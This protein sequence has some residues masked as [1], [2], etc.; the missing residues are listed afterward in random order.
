MAKNQTK[1]RQ[2]K[3]WRIEVIDSNRFVVQEQFSKHWR[4]TPNQ[5]KCILSIKPLKQPVFRA[6]KVKADSESTFKYLNQRT[7]AKIHRPSK[8]TDKWTTVANVRLH[9]HPERSSVTDD[10][11][12]KVPQKFFRFVSYNPS[13]LCK[14]YFRFPLIW[15]LWRQQQQRALFAWP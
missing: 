4:K 9:L 12:W 5:C 2:P 13:T 7:M 3:I 8:L 10:T 14:Y 15:M 11:L 1:V 6:G